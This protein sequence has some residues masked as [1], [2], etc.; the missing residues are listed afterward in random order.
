MENGSLVALTGSDSF[1]ELVKRYA[2]E[3]WRCWVILRDFRIFAKYCG[4]W[5]AICWWIEVIS[6]A[7]RGGLLVT[8][9]KCAWLGRSDRNLIGIGQF[10]FGHSAL[11]CYVL[12]YWRVARAQVDIRPHNRCLAFPDSMSL[13]NVIHRVS[14]HIIGE[15]VRIGIFQFV[16]RSLEIEQYLFGF[17]LD[18]KYIES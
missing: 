17:S 2:E 4:S 7:L 8:L 14:V 9:A 12:D 16:F 5:D 11:K 3:I 15:R 1:S 10:S 13:S 6:E 18:I